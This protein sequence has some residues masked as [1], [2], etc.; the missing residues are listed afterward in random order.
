MSVGRIFL[1]V[2]PLLTALDPASAHAAK[3]G[4]FAGL[5]DV[6]HGRRI[7]MECRGR[8]SPTVVLISGK[9]NGAADWS[10]ILDPAAPV[11][12]SPYDMA[13]HE[14]DAA[15]YRSG[16]AVFPRV[17]RFTR[18]CAYDRPGTRIE[19]KNIS[20]PVLQPHSVDQ[21]VGDL[22]KLLA[23]SGER[24]PYVLVA[25]SYGGLIARLFARKHPKEVVGLVMIDIVSEYMQRAA[26]P[27]ALAKWDELNRTS[28]PKAPEAVELIDAFAKING[29]AKLP[30]V[31]TVVLSADKP[32][33]P[34]QVTALT[35]KV[36]GA[37]VTWDNWLAAQDLLAAS[38]PGRHVKH[39][40]SGHFIYT[41]APALVVDA[42]R[43]VVDEV[44]RN[45]ALG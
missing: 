30:H 39:T 27:Q 37:V 18:A 24:G 32:W 40:H 14:E 22:Q 5:V 33:D 15:I 31:P 17:S 9:G 4:D 2:L 34:E 8:G 21:D 6:G 45:G 7:Y 3:G 29:A 16:A 25:H 23:A 42:V 11:R 41:Y 44:R 43:E 10:E 36:G 19:G 28:S 13:G 26:S 12:K 38:A 1:V 35:K 20:T